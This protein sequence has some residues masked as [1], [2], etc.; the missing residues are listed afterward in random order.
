MEDKIID[1]T[2]AHVEMKPEL[3][4]SKTSL[5]T[6]TTTTTEL[7][8]STRQAAKKSG[9]TAAP[10]DMASDSTR[11]TPLAKPVES[12]KDPPAGLNATTQDVEMEPLHRSIEIIEPAQLPQAH[13]KNK[14][15]A[16]NKPCS[17][18]LSG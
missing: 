15:A 11:R 16:L 10:L 13:N 1:T 9:L 2:P 18:Y 14:R 7:R 5:D 17:F 12:K 3:S 4:P 6:T 8:R